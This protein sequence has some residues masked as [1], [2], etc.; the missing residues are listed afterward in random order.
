[1]PAKSDSD[2]MGGFA[3]G[4]SVLEAF[5]KERERLT[6]AD[7]S[8]LTGLDRA[9]SRRCLLTLQRLGYATHDGKNFALT[10]RVLSLGRAYLAT[11]PLHEQIQPFLDRFAAAI[12]ESC[13]CSI[14]DDTE[15][16]YI[17]RAAQRRV[18]SIG[19]GVGSRLPAYCASM[20]RVLL[21]ALSDEEVTSA[22]DR[23]D[24]R[25]LTAKT[26]TDRAALVAEIVRVRT[27]GFAIIDEEL[28]IG[29]RS[30]A[31][32]IRNV[33]GRVV[34]ALNTGVQTSRI[35][36]DRLRGEI[37]PALLDVQRKLAMVVA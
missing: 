10:V 26:L 33:S 1:M 36:I 23:T 25:P 19:L 13:S 8:R 37:L 21:A 12:Q 35:S 14:L 2:L 9:T 28:E 20:G 18:M 31:I 32:P 34:A 16:V 3:K 24:I 5:G 15:I 6:I 7:V 29:L 27:Q 4:L 11:T 30:L 22:L 17:A